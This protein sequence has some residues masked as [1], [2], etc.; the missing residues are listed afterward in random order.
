MTIDRRRRGLL[1]AGSFFL[2]AALSILLL[3]LIPSVH[4]D[5]GPARLTAKGTTGLGRT[6]VL[7]P[8]LGTIEADT[9]PGPLTV[10]LSLEEVDVQ[11]LADRL[12]EPSG[13]GKLAAI[14]EED[15]T[16]LAVQLAVR[17]A[18]GGVVLGA[19]GLALL[20]HRRRRYILG[21][22]AGGFLAVASLVTLAATSYSVEAFEEPTF[23]GALERAPV[24]IEALNENEI[25]IPEVRSRFETGAARLTDL[26][27]LLAEPNLD[28]RSDSVAILH[29]SDIHSNPIG[30]EIALQLARRFDVDAVLD[31]GDLTNFGV[32]LETRI[33]TLVQRIGE[34][35]IFVPGNHDANAVVSAM[36]RL[37]H[38]T[39]LDGGLT[40][41]AGITIQGFRDP[42]Y[43]NW[44]A[45]EPEEA[46]DIR[47]A[48][49]GPIAERV[50]DAEPDVLAVHDRRLADESFGLV[51]L[52]LSGHYHKRIVEED[53]GTRLFA[54]GTTG[55]SGL[56]SFTLEADMDYEAEIVYFRGGSAIAVD[57]VTFEGL[58]SN[59]I[60]ERTSLDPLG[61]LEPPDEPSPTPSAT[62][63]GR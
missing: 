27:S 38:V 10:D 24:V 51:P 33:T 20:P 29:I 48:A 17:L 26:L 22:A 15:L 50:R 57:Y 18:L 47:S 62:P 5:V 37:D 35:Y 2:G 54:V 13:P 41:V 16:H 14:V 1:L 43:S 52:I 60:I 12:Q 44:N 32:R 25:S 11:A 21:G 34:P 40:E 19:V 8:P 31:T 61:P 49:G 59:F 39:V 36:A 55:A 42:T 46:A 53:R 6:N 3:R 28:P 45:I 56:K 58:A 23:T 7:I 30:L 4:H 9:H 63:E